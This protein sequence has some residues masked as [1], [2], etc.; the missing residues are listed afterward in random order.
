MNPVPAEASKSGSN[1]GSSSEDYDD[2]G[3]SSHTAELRKR[4]P[5]LET[6][7]H[8]ASVS[9]S[10]NGS[11]GFIVSTTAGHDAAAIQEAVLHGLQRMPNN[12]NDNGNSNSN[13]NGAARGARRSERA[14]FA[15]LVFTRKFSAFDRQ[16]HDAANSPFHGFFTL[17]WMGV[18]FFVVKIGA[19]NWKSYGSPLGTNEI[20]QSMFRKDLLVLL[21]ADGVLCAM[22]GVSW[23]LQRA[24]KAGYV[25]WDRTGWVIQNV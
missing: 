14:K 25:D 22:T 18:F 11:R 16:N 24:V 7:A 23:L 2:L 8:A 20:M 10:A 1:S 17:F 13:S 9:K 4:L 15:D 12:D 6:H 21:V 19:D 5:T 3:A